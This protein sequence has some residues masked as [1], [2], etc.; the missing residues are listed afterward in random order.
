LVHIEYINECRSGADSVDI[1]K[2][3]VTSAEDRENFAKSGTIAVS[4]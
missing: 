3:I 4:G 1:K 2:H